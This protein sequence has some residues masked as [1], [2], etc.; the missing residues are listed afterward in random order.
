MRAF[1][2]GIEFI[3]V[4]DNK[5]PDRLF[6]DPLRLH[7]ILLNLCNNAIK[8]TEVGKVILS[9]NLVEKEGEKVKVI[10]EV[11]DTG[12]GMTEEQIKRLF[13]AFSQADSSITRKYGGTGLGL[14]I[15]KNLATLMQGGKTF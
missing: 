11:R 5:I 2:K 1:E 10:F 8:F 14:I 13:K 6:G 4:P 15:S 7:Q 3:I 9:L 12:I